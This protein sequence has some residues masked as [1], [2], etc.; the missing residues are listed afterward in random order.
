[1]IKITDSY[2]YEADGTQYTLIHKGIRFKTDKHTKKETA[3]SVSFTETLGYYTT[4]ETLLKACAKRIT[5][6]RINSGAIT[7]LSEHIS[8][9]KQLKSSFEQ[10]LADFS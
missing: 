7:T 3:E 10:L 5:A 4:L 2:Y 8:E 1:M 9:L 6:E